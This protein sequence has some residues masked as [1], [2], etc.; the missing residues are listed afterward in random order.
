MVKLSLSNNPSSLVSVFCINCCTHFCDQI[1][2]RNNSRGGK[3][4]ILAHGFKGFNPWSGGLAP[5]S[6]AGHPNSEIMWQRTD[7]FLVNRKKGK[8]GD[9]YNLQRH[10]PVVGPTSQRF[11]NLPKKHHQLRPKIKTMSLWGTNTTGWSLG[12]KESYCIYTYLVLNSTLSSLQASSFIPCH[13]SIIL[14]YWTKEWDTTRLVKLPR[15]AKAAEAEFEHIVSG[16]SIHAECNPTALLGWN[17]FP[18]TYME[19]LKK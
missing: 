3:G 15:C 18:K 19:F 11:H 1:P 5:C 10:P 6:R 9:W 13:G 2:N 7:G 14:C 17:S 4:F 16:C 8:F 12:D